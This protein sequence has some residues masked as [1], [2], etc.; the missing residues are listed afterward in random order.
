MS[1]KPGN[2]RVYEIS[3]DTHGVGQPCWSDTVEDLVK[4]LEDNLLPILRP[5]ENLTIRTVEVSREEFDNLP[6]FLPED[7]L[8]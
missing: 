3:S 7:W 5:G 2:I 1:R 4:E 6:E 8:K